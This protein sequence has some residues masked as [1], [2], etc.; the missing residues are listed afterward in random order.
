MPSPLNPNNPE[1]RAQK[2]PHILF[3]A[4]DPSFSELSTNHIHLSFLLLTAD[5]ARAAGLCRE[6][7]EGPEFVQVSAFEDL[8]SHVH[9]GS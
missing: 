8:I 1:L 9:T 6:K 4:L 2:K 7:S 5:P 3:P